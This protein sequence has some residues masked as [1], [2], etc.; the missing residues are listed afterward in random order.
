MGYWAKDGSYTYDDNDIQSMESMNESQGQ[1]YDR[2]QRVVINN[3][4]SPFTPQEE[5]KREEEYGRRVEERAKWYQGNKMYREQQA[6]IKEEENQRELK[7]QSY[8][9]AKS[10]YKSLSTMNKIWLKVLGKDISN[11]N[12]NNSVETLD[13]LYRGKSR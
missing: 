4:S 9:A 12:V 11:Y 13:S 1:R 8:E 6:Q 5:A 7:K 10:R 3:S 2:L